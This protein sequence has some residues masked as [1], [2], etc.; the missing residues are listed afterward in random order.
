MKRYILTAAATALAVLALF[1]ALTSAGGSKPVT[2]VLKVGFLYENDESTPHTYNFVLAQRA[3]E[4]QFRGRVAVLV[5]SNV[6]SSVAADSLRELAKKGCG[7]IFTNSDSDQV[8]E[9]AKDYPKTEFCQ[10]SYTT[11]WPQDAPV[12]YHTFNGKIH[13]GRY[14]SGIAAGMKLSQLMDAGKIGPEE[15]LVGFVAS[16][17]TAEEISDFTAFLLG[18]RSVVK[19]ARML[20]KYTGL[21]SSYSREKACAK[22]LMEK[23][24]VAIAQSTVTIGPAVACEE[25]AGERQVFHVG[26]DQSMLDVAPA[27]ALVATRINWTPYVTQAVEAVLEGKT[28][29]SRVDGLVRGRDVS[30]G[31]ERGW[32]EMLDLNPLIAAEG[33]QEAMNRVIEKFKSGQDDVFRGDYVGVDPNDPL[34]VYDLKNGFKENKDSS[35][36]AFHYILQDVITVVD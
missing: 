27:T 6:H 14:V 35:A 29:E 34:D 18:V 36:P 25:A 19:D 26:F 3:V 10:E 2:D 20:V 12:N 4:N 32:V 1:Y 13:Q 11:V 16:D 23:G 30:A 24:C 22:A 8:A 7:I 17:P 5:K 9:V 21:G 33:T 15:A 31:F 28:I